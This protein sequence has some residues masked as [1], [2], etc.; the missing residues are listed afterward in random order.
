MSFI[1]N[2][3]IHFYGLAARILALFQKKAGLFVRGRKNWREDL[4][5][6]IGQQNDWVWFHCASL[7]EFEQG[8]NLIETFRKEHS[9]Y[10]ILLTFFSPSGYEIRK[11]YAGADHVCYLPL[12]TQ[13]NARNFLNITHPKLV[14]FIKYDLWLNLLGETKRR[15][16][17]TFLVSALVGEKS[18]FLRSS[19]RGLYRKAFRDL[20]WIFTQ[21]QAS[22]Q[23]LQDFCG[24]DRISVAGDTRF[25][26]AVEL[27]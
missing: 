16:I 13:Q 19:F 25:D 9:E 7:G 21:D 2:F 23:R 5:K 1:Y 18:K 11:D 27:P 6:Q 8:R 3:G 20:D 12:D 26:R 10:K 22:K 24:S 15:S 14:F 4:Q 17:P